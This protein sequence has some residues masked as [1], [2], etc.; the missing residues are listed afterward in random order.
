MKKKNNLINSQKKILNLNKKIK[1]ERY[2]K[3]IT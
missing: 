3:K 2:S 1:R